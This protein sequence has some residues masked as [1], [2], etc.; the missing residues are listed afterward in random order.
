MQR[1]PVAA[2]R[3]DSSRT[4][5]PSVHISIGRI[6][7]TAETPAREPRA[8]RSTA[9]TATSLASYLA[10]RARGDKRGSDR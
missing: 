2:A 10:A 9:A 7:V 4:A 5:A 1:E 6:V 8:P 3:L